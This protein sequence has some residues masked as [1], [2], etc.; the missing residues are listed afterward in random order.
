MLKHSP[1]CDHFPL[2]LCTQCGVSAPQLLGKPV[3]GSLRKTHLWDI[4]KKL[5]KRFFDSYWKLSYKTTSKLQ[6]K[7]GSINSPRNKCANKFSSHLKMVI[8]SRFV[9][10]SIDAIWKDGS[11][12]L[13]FERLASTVQKWE[14]KYYQ[15]HVRKI[16]QSS[17]R[18]IVA[19]DQRF[20]VKIK[21]I[22]SISKFYSRFT[23]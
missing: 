9:R 4:D 2:K 15:N 19:T 17:Y 8:D 13:L 10:S 7:W 12:E 1:G 18:R 23:V 21:V 16:Y 3:V 6:L 5:I 14:H 20:G 22:R 11:N